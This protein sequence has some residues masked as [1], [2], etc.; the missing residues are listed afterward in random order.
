MYRTFN[1]TRGTRV[2]CTH[3]ECVFLTQSVLFTPNVCCSH[4]LKHSGP[5]R[6]PL[7]DGRAVYRTLNLTRGTKEDI[8]PN[9]VYGLYM[10]QVSLSFSLSLSLSP[11]LSLSHFILLYFTLSLSLYL[12]F[13]LVISFSISLSLAHTHTLSL[14]LSLSHT[15][16]L[17]G[18]HNREVRACV[19]HLSGPCTHN[20]NL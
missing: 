4:S 15:H 13:F 10:L 2:C 20:P 19:P 18:L 14:S 7:Y 12:S 9:W 17:S 6:H 8:P 11:S 1:L 16:S 5:G 3:Y